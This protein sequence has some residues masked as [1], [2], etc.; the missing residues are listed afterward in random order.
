MMML[1]CLG[2][3]VPLPRTILRIDFH[4]CQVVRVLGRSACA[5]VSSLP[6]E[7][8]ASPFSAT[9]CQSSSMSLTLPNG[10]PL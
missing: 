10:L 4:R 3:P 7:D 8:P 1:I 2:A 5:G 9:A 6:A